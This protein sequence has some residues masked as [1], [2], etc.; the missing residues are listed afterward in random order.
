MRSSEV[1]ELI[2]EKNYAGF[3]HWMRGQT[4]GLYPDGGT[5]FYDCDVKAYMKKLKS[6]YDRQNDPDAWD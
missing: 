1:K 6:G 3:I 5:D 4:C 2:G